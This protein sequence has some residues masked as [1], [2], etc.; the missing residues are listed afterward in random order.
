MA[1]GEGRF[2]IELDPR[3]PLVESLV[4]RRFLEV[5]LLS[6]SGARADPIASTHCEEA[7]GNVLVKVIEAALDKRDYNVLQE[8]SAGHPLVVIP[9]P[10]EVWAIQFSVRE[11]ALEPAKRLLMPNVHSQ[12]D[13]WLETIAAEVS[14]ADKKAEEVALVKL[15]HNREFHGKHDGETIRQK[16]RG[17]QTSGATDLPAR[18]C[19]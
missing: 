18:G 2:Q 6:Q 17:P 15:I 13:L 19:K 10:V 4:F 14:F 12:R 16:D 7:F 11:G 3:G 1:C 9:P 5:K 8:S